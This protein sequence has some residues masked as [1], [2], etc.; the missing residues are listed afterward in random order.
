MFP[1]PP[2]RCGLGFGFGF[3][4]FPCGF[5]GQRMSEEDQIDF[6]GEKIFLPCSISEDNLR[7]ETWAIKKISPGPLT[8]EKDQIHLMCEED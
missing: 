2:F 8:R 7:L 1:G 3:G 4:S 6:I 5:C